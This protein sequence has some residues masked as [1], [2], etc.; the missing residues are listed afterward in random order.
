VNKRQSNRFL[1]AVRLIKSDYN[2][3]L[4]VGSRDKALKEFLKKDVNYQGIDFEDGQEVLGCNLENGIPFPDKSFDVVFALD[5]LEHVDN[6]HFLFKEVIRVSKNEVVVALPNMFYWKARL[7]F[8]RGKDISS[9][10]VFCVDPCL[11]RHRWVTSYNSSVKFIK[12]NAPNHD[13]TIVKEYYQYKSKL[14]R[15]IDIKLSRKW[16][17][18]FVHTIIFHIRKNNNDLFN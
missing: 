4:D 18:L 5:V 13:I 16:P 8:W 3:V 6:L 7:R 11:D 10:Y 12:H 2:F 17:N 1:S 9:K 15:F 14:L